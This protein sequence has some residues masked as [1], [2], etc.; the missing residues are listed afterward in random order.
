MSPAPLL[1]TFVHV[2]QHKTG[3]TSI[4]MF[5]KEQ[6]DTL[7]RHG[8][9]VPLPGRIHALLNVYALQWQRMSTVKEDLRRRK[10]VFFFWSLG[11]RL[12]RQITRHYEQA[13]AQGC[14]DVLWSNEGLYLLN[15]TAEY[16]KLVRLFVPHSSQTV[17]VCCFRDVESYRASYRAQLEKDGRAFS[18]DPDSFRYVEP[19]SWLFDFERKRNLLLRTFDETITFDYHAKDNVK[20]FFEMLDYTVEGTSRYRHNITS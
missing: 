5:L 17:A 9:Y 14:R 19:D 16:S 12:R 13:R 4:Q 20:R 11:W 15:S 8:L 2:G 1:R 3:T 10:S 18:T 7:R 6:A